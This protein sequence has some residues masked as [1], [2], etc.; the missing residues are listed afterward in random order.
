VT[1]SRSPSARAIAI[2]F[3]RVDY[4]SLP[5]TVGIARAVLVTVA[6][7][8]APHGRFVVI[9]AVIV[10][11]YVV[12]IVIMERRWRHEPLGAT[13]AGRDQHSEGG[14]PFRCGWCQSCFA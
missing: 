2:P 9:P 5:L 7:Y 3:F 1:L 4:T 12:T 13:A 14:A 6:W 11:V 10:G 8:L